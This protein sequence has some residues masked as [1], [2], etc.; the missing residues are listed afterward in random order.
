MNL[1]NI[2]TLVNGK[3]KVSDGRIYVKLIGIQNFR[4]LKQYM[5]K[6]DFDYVY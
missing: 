1:E 4:P 2:E 6:N 5:S 3:A